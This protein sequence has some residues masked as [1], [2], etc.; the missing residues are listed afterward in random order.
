LVQHLANGESCGV[1]D[2]ISYWGEEAL[3]DD[4]L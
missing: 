3:P 4:S 2:R 1:I